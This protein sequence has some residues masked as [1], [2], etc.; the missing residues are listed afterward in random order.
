MSSK[1][2]IRSASVSMSAR[3]GRRRDSVHPLGPEALP[4]LALRAMSFLT[5]SG[6]K[7]R[8]TG[9]ECGSGGVVVVEGGW[10]AM[11]WLHTSGVGS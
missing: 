3:R 1:I 4:K 10:R 7:W 11:S 8:V 5:L 9:E 6:S 2:K